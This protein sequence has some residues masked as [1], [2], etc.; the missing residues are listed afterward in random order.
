MQDWTDSGSKN[1]HML[2]VEGKLGDIRPTG[3][4][5]SNG[6]NEVILKIN[7]DG[8]IEPGPGYTPTDAGEAVIDG[9]RWQLQ[10]LINRAVEERLADH[11]KQHDK[12]ED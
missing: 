1:F 8:T 5:F 6:A 10:Y 2:P 4:S 11:L 12:P 7:S 3:F 9:M